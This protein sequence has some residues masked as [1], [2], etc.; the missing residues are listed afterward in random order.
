MIL[1][2]FFL[3]ILT[4]PHAAVLCWEC[5]SCFERILGVARLLGIWRGVELLVGSRNKV[6]S[7][8]SAQ[9]R[10][11]FSN[12]YFMEVQKLETFSEVLKISA[13]IR[14][15][16]KNISWSRSGGLALPYLSERRK[17]STGC[18]YLH[19]LE[20][21]QRC[22]CEDSLDWFFTTSDKVREYT[23][24]STLEMMSNLICSQ[25]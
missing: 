23:R 1:F 8:Y 14:G 18:F 21:I 24:E 12:T 25:C 10:Q 6:D 4:G 11:L 13:G 9:T 3:S 15:M 19:A 5:I 16:R 20:K 22:H 17:S 7:S 2:F